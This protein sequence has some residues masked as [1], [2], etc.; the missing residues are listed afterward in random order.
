MELEDGEYMDMG[1]G[2]ARSVL[3]KLERRGVKTA[4]KALSGNG[5]NVMSC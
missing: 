1:V 5:E 2:T 3:N 4:G